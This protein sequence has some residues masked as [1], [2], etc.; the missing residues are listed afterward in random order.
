M[1]GMRHSAGSPGPSP[2]PIRTTARSP[3]SLFTTSVE[4][5]AMERDLGGATSTLRRRGEDQAAAKL[6]MKQL[7]F[8]RRIGREKAKLGELEN[9]IQ[10]SR[11]EISRRMKFLEKEA[12][13]SEGL[14]NIIDKRVGSLLSVLP[15]SGARALLRLPAHPP[16][17]TPTPN[18]HSHTRMYVSRA[19]QPPAG[20]TTVWRRL[21]TSSSYSS[22][23]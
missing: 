8:T 18:T 23:R 10:A 7:Q 9:R 19:P 1:T 2:S 4:T 20:P 16:P 13:T 3:G 6:M 12:N 15:A 21:S 14:R 22:T 11:E 17:A 5:D